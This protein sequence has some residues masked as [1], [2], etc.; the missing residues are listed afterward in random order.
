MGL[1]LPGWLRAPCVALTAARGSRG[2]IFTARAGLS[3]PI[4]VCRATER[5]ECRA[6]AAWQLCA[7]TRAAAGQAAPALVQSLLRSSAG[8]KPP[9]VDQ[10]PAESQG[11]G[12]P[13]QVGGS[14]E[15]PSAL[16]GV[17][18]HPRACTQNCTFSPIRRTMRAPEH[19]GGCVGARHP[20]QLPI[21]PQPT[22]APSRQGHGS[23][24]YK[25]FWLP[26]SYPG[27]IAQ[28]PMAP[29]RLP[30]QSG[31]VRSPS[32]L[33]HWFPLHGKTSP[34]HVTPGMELAPV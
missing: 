33:E 28:S 29:Q 9:C 34:S 26:V 7:G 15:T 16:L 17:G 25:S 30:Q 3:A 23:Q 19:P 20:A 18:P 8:P 27:D 24:W 14:L 5:C 4:C 1:P 32:R 2:L 11:L 31:H 21:S 12:E 13:W 6:R 10:G 22:R